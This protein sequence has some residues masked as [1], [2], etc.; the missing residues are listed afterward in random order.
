MKL[1]SFIFTSQTHTL[2]SARVAAPNQSEACAQIQSLLP[3]APLTFGPRPASEIILSWM[4]EIDV[5][6]AHIISVVRR[7]GT[8]LHNG[9]V[10]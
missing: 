2:Q 9:G 8:T 5:P 10:L 6:K 4:G 3:D 7:D 1:W